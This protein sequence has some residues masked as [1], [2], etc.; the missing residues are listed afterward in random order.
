MLFGLA[1]NLM[2][3][4]SIYQRR[5]KNHEALE[6]KLLAFLNQDGL[7]PSESRETLQLV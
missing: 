5:F 3:L 6:G 2:L 4:Y 1:Q 7:T